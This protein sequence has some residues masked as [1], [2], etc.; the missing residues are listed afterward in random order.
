MK[1]APVV[2]IIAISLLAFP[3]FISIGF[4]QPL[5]LPVGCFF[6]LVIYAFFNGN[7]NENRIKVLLLASSLIYITS[8]IIWPKYIALRPP[9]LPPI[10]IQRFANLL[11]ISSFVFAMFCSN[12]FKKEI[13]NSYN[14]AKAFWIFFG[15]LVFFRFASVFMSAKL[16][17]SMYI[18]MSDLFVHWFFIF[19]GVF[20]GSSYR[21]FMLFSK[22]IVCCFFLNFFL[23]IGEFALGRNLFLQFV[24]AADPALEWIMKEKTR[25]GAYRVH[26]VFNHPILFAEFASIGFC[27]AVFMS[28]RIKNTAWRYT[29]I[30]AAVF[31][32]SVML[33]LS[34]SRS[35][36]VAAAIVISLTALSPLANS[37]FRGQMNLKTAALWSFLIIVVAIAVSILG[38]L[39]YDLTFG[40]YTSATAGSDTARLIMLERTFD[41]LIESPIIGHGVAQAAELVGIEIFGSASSSHTI[42][43]LYISYTVESGL[44]AIIA[45]IA[46]F[47]IGTFKSFRASF[48]GREENWFMMYTIGLS[49]ITFA[50]FKTIL[51][52]PDHNFFLFVMLGISV[53]EI[54]RNSIKQTHTRGMKEVQRAL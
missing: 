27:F 5:V 3:Y 25:G 12:W 26:S 41:K 13:A 29:A 35:G 54:A 45:F 8:S 24:N 49:I 36:Y 9:G 4:Y 10:S 14:S 16:F 52:L 20:I 42:D 18:F 34:G 11:A 50:L 39:V 48:Y 37:L 53:S 43:S 32:V 19:I 33:I 17:H 6:I 28:S 38:I 46:L 30:F 1:T 7:K 51:S 23:A 44:F 31:C 47:I 22:I 2:F 21:N 15:I 40:K